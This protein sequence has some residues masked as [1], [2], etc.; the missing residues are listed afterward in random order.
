MNCGEQ[1]VRTADWGEKRGG[2]DRAAQRYR[3]PSPAA[4]PKDR[5]EE[6]YATAHLAAQLWSQTTDPHGTLVEA[7]WLYRRLELPIP[8][9]VRFHPSHM[10]R[11]VMVAAAGLVAPVTAIQRTFLEPDG[12]GY[13]KPKK[14]LG[15]IKGRPIV[16]HANP[17]SLALVIGEGVE[18][19]H[20]LARAMNVDGWATAG[21]SFIPHF[22]DV[23]P[24]TVE[25][26][27]ILVDSGAEPECHQL[28]RGLE[29]RG[30]EALLT[31][32]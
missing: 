32:G 29:A 7:Y 15:P 10:G 25:S 4:P 14:S 13:I 9:S 27:T 11:P 18:K 3:N 24:P 16:V 23:V 20:A 17:E 6:E 5:R 30:I 12:Q 8:P 31:G 28:A 19:T 1:G 26:V 22:V 2:P 21:K